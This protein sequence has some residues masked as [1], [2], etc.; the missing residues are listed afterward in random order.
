MSSIALREIT[1]GSPS[2]PSQGIPGVHIDRMVSQSFHN[3]DLKC[4]DSIL[5]SRKINRKN[6]FGF[7]INFEIFNNFEQISIK[8]AP[9][10]EAMM[11]LRSGRKVPFIDQRVSRKSKS[12]S[13]SSHCSSIGRKTPDKNSD[14]RDELVLT[15]Q[16]ALQVK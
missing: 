13:G 11:V 9:M 12:R 5:R 8:I 1:M 10:N 15:V 14:D 6:I 3:N 16:K 2:S 7:Y 4:I